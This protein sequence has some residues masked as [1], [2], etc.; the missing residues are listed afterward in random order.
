M[1]KILYVH[2]CI[3]IV[4]RL[5]RPMG[6]GR[7]DHY[8]IRASG[9]WYRTFFETTARVSTTA[10]LIFTHTNIAR[11]HKSWAIALPMHT[12]MISQV[13]HTNK[14][15]G[16]ALAMRAKHGGLIGPSSLSTMGTITVLLHNTF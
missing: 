9:G 14:I 5:C 1:T 7:E 13:T 8:Y 6:E 3:L 15:I 4:Q 16:H 2:A 10:F 11:L 12:H